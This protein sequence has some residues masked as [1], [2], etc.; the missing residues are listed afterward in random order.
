MKILFTILL[1][2]TFNLSAQKDI[3]LFHEN[4]VECYY[5]EKTTEPILIYDRFNGKIIIALKPL[6]DMKQEMAE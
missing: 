6:K 2:T 3:E 4:F 5:S 1:L